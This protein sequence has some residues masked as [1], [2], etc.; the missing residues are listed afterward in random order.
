MRAYDVEGI[1][2]VEEVDAVNL[3]AS[4]KQCQDY[5]DLHRGQIMDGRGWQ[6]CSSK[7]CIHDHPKF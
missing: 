3:V 6:S 7:D 2:G 4:G 5:G 1:R